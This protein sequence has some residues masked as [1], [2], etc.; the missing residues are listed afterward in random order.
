[1]I[2]DDKKRGDFSLHFVPL[3]MTG[4]FSFYRHKK[5]VPSR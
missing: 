1:M 5:N 3:T 4:I 2:Y